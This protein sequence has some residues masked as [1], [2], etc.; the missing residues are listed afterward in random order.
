MQRLVWHVSIGAFLATCTVPNA[1][2]QKAF[3]W[4]EIRQKFEATNPTLQAGEIGIRES[5]AEE[6]TADLRPNPDITGTIDQINPFSTQPSPSGGANGYRPFAFAFP[7]TSMSYLHERRHKRELRLESAK[8]AT[9]IA[10]SNQADLARN[11][12][13]NLRNGFIQTLQ[14]KSVLVLAR[15][16]LSYWDHVLSVNRDRYKAGDIAQVDLDRL[17]LQRIQYESDVQTAEVN[18]RTAK[19]QLL[20]LLND[21]TPVEQFDVTGLFDFKEEV[22]PLD[23]FRRIAVDTRPDLKAAVQ[24][25]DKAD[26][27]HRLAVANGSVDPTFAVDFARNPPIPVYF[28]ASVTIPLRIFDRNQG[29]KLRTQLDIGR[30]EK[31]RDA[32]RAQVFSDV[33]SAYATVSSNLTLLRPYKAKYLKQAERVR[34]TMAFAY[35]RGG[36]SL[37]DFLNAQSDYRSIQLNYLNLVGSYLA[38]A[39]Q[40][41]LAVGREVI[42]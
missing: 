28:G 33:D 13:F 3:T 2:P 35:Q 29:E 37:L 18:L 23:E 6:I 19:I 17:E 11:L 26:T 39:S 34:D 24:S 7:A 31:L 30:S 27:D 40:L 20:M 42:E 14:A 8:K 36:V 12:L 32:T 41:N 4:Q 10:A 15:E 1:L 22:L 25:V 9:D 38:A 21:R 5:R 16:N